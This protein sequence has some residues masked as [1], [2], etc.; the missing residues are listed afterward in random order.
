MIISRSILLTTAC[1][2]IFQCGVRGAVFRDTHRNT[3]LSAGVVFIYSLLHVYCGDDG[4]VKKL[5]LVLL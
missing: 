1:H 2:A 3:A 4:S 5:V